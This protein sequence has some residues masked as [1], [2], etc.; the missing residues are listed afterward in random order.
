MNQTQRPASAPWSV[1]AR[2]D[3]VPEEGAHFDLSA[4]DATRAA[5]AALTSLQ[6][7]NRLE[8]SFDLSRRGRGLQVVGEVSAMVGQIC[9]VTLEPVENEIREAINLVFV[10]GAR[11]PQAEADPSAADDLGSEDLGAK[12]PPEELVDGT[13]DL[14]ALAVEFLLL[15]IDP[16][17]RKPDAVFEAPRIGDA[18]AHPFAALAKLREKQDRGKE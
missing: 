17:P 12:E 18:T 7:L 5:I 6:A 3:N 1:K 10:P 8:A 13:V 4:D 2:I 16:Y 15:G 14:A 9:V 11:A